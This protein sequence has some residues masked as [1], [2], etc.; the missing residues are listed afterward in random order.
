MQ[1]ILGPLLGA[2][3]KSVLYERFVKSICGINGFHGYNVCRDASEHFNGC[4]AVV[5]RL[6]AFLS[7]FVAELPK[8]HQGDMTALSLSHIHTRAHPHTQMHMDPTHTHTHT[9]TQV[10]LSISSSLPV[11]H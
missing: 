4:P 11:G 5:T 6:S 2:L 7:C 8:D 1:F 3:S 9:H 10:H